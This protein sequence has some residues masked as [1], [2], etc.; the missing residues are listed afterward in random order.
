M[1]KKLDASSRTM[2]KG[3]AAHH[4]EMDSID[5]NNKAQEKINHDRIKKTFANSEKHLSGIIRHNFGVK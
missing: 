4:R 2:L 5:K 3:T 1:G